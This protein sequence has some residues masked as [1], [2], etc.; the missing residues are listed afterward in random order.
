MK[1][2]L[3]KIWP[4]DKFTSRGVVY[5]ALGFAGLFYEL[6]FRQPPELLI[7]IFYVAIIGIGFI[8]IFFLKE[9]V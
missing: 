2:S 5:A 1:N 4:K 9:H 6:I 3:S 7:L 8:S